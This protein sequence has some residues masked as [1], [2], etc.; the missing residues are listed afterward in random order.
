MKVHLSVDS[1]VFGSLSDDH[2]AWTRE[3]I[4]HSE[5]RSC[6]GLMMEVKDRQYLTSKKE[7]VTCKHCVRKT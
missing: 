1:P 6:D 4:I 2:C 3:N 7:L 5:Q